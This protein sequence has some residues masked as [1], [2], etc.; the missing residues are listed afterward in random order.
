MSHCVSLFLL[1]INRWILLHGL[2]W[3]HEGWCYLTPLTKEEV[4]RLDV[5]ERGSWGVNGWESLETKF[6][7]RD[8]GWAKSLKN[9]RDSFRG[10]EEDILRSSEKHTI[11]KIQLPLLKEPLPNSNFSDQNDSHHLDFCAPSSPSCDRFLWLVGPTSMTPQFT[12]KKRAE[13]QRAGRPF[14]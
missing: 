4:S 2:Q 14:N 13:R 11:S 8:R 9:Q 5:G 10:Q 1:P 12:P 3:R 7:R 6:G